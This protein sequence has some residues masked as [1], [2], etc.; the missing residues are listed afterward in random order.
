MTYPQML[1]PISYADYI[2]AAWY[3]FLQ[4]GGAVAYGFCCLIVF[5]QFYL[6]LYGLRCICLVLFVEVGSVC[7]H[8][9]GMLYSFPPYTVNCYTMPAIKVSISLKSEQ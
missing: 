7:S 9:T 4:G 8:T 5:F 3:A 6:A 2:I 1:L